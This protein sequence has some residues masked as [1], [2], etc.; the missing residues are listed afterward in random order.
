MG[1]RTF[2]DVVLVLG[3]VVAGGVLIGLLLT[4]RP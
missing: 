3:L 1:W 4:G 2:R